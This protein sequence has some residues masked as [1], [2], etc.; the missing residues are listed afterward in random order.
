MLLALINCYQL[1]DDMDIKTK[2]F[3]AEQIQEIL[4]AAHDEI[5]N[6]VVQNAIREIEGP[7]KWTV[8]DA[9]KRDVAEWYREEVSEDVRLALQSNKEMIVQMAVS[10]A[11]S[12]AQQMAEAMAK[13]LADNLSKS[14]GADKIF[15]AMF[16]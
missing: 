10:F 5:K 16:D 7:V 1:E 11:E 15:K 12:T 4:T 14:W 8:A 2:H 3:S 9:I 6:S 13:R